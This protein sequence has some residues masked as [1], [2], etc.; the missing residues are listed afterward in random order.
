[1][2]LLALSIDI[3]HYLALVGNPSLLFLDE[4]ISDALDLRSDWIESI[5]VILDPIFLFLDKCSF[6][7]IPIMINETVTILA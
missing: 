1:M 2:H 3:S 7:F 4:A 6:K 5:I